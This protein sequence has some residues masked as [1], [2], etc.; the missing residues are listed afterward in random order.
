ML[1]FI[2]FRGEEYNNA[3]KAF[4][5]PDFV[6]LVH[7]HR[8]YGDVDIDNDVLVFGPKADPRVISEYSDQDHARH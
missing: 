6:H 3:V 2:G 7:D 4:G 8:M 1:H 5:K